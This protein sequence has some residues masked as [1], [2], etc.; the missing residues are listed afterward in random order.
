MNHIL[1]YSIPNSH[2]LVGTLV[3]LTLFAAPV[4]SGQ[5]YELSLLN[6]GAVFSVAS[7]LQDVDEDGD[8]DVVITRRPAGDIPGGV[9]WLENDGTGQFPRHELFEDESL[10]RPGDVDAC[11]CDGDG[12]VDYVV[13]DR[14]SGTDDGQLFWMERQDDDS[15]IKWTIEA[16]ADFEQADVADFDDDGNPDVVAVGFGQSTVNLYLNDGNL[17]FSKA[18]IAEDITQ[19]ALVEA[20]DL[21][22]DGDID[23]VY[24]GPD[25]RILWNDGN[26]AFEPGPQLL[27]GADNR[28]TIRFGLTTAD[29]N[30]DGVLDVVAY[31]GLGSGGLYFFDGANNFASTFIEQV[32]IDLGGGIVVED[33]DD[34]GLPDIIRQNIGDDVLSILYQDDPMQFRRVVLD[35]NWDNRGGSHMSVGDLDDDGDP[36]LFFPENGNVDGDLSWYENI[37][38]MLHRHQLHMELAGIRAPKLADLDGDGDLDVV[39]ALTDD[40]AIEDEIIWFE[41]RG[42]VGFVEWRISDSLNFPV[43][44]EIADLDGDGTM[45]VLASAR[46]DNDLLW[47]RRDGNL[48]ERFVIEGNA[49]QPMGIAAGDVDSDGDTDVA[50]TSF[51]DSKVYWYDN[52]GTGSFTRRVVDADLSEPTEIEAADLD[53]DGDVDLVVI[54]ADVENSVVAYFNDGDEEFAREILQADIDATDV[55]VGDWNGS[56][57]ADILVSLRENMQADPD[58]T[59]LSNDGAGSFTASTLITDNRNVTALHIADLDDDG[60]VDLLVG[61]DN[62]TPRIRSYLNEGGAAVAGAELLSDVTSRIAGLD[63]G[64]VDG[65]GTMDFVASDHE[66]HN[67]MLFLGGESGPVAVEPISSDLPTAFALEQNYPN[68]FNPVT[69]ISFSLDRPS[70]VDLRVYDVLGREVETLVSGSLAAGRFE[71]HWDAADF[72]GGTYLYRIVTEG[73]SA[74]RMLTLVK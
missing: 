51:A 20:A 50:L 9:E 43:D 53:D 30:A 63:A 44:V 66:G 23:V 74:S 40:I 52:D 37:D 64:D 32:G 36:D 34:N 59:L 15:F 18:V 10:A 70:R 8:L 27:T 13:A 6:K 29:L 56:G 55:E 2:L 4:A 25:A 41:N 21:D 72:A 57:A 46:D 24:T 71:V 42:E 26:G 67:L 62:A 19:A 31:R 38:G 7:F 17:N 58:V 39:V 73:R 12:D 69:T 3:L 33:F 1:R 54:S 45:D 35:Y 68:P 28:T 16:G 49:N 11:D 65:D 22:G 61:N 5:E 60:S 48:W 47:F 14:G